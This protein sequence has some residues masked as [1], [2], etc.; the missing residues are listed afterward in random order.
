[1]TRHVCF[2]TDE[3][4]PFTTGGIGRVLH[5]LVRQGLELEPDTEFHFLM[6]EGTPAT[7]DAVATAFGPR[8][9][10][11][12]AAMRSGWDACTEFEVTYPPAAAFTD[13]VWHAQS[14]DF[15]R[16]LKRLNAGGTR[17]DVVEFPDYRGWAFC[18][19]QEKLLGLDFQDTLVSVRLHSTDGVLQHFEPRPTTLDQASRWELERKALH[20]A[21]LVIAHLPCIADFNRQHYGFEEAW[22]KKVVFQFPPVTSGISSRAAQGA[23]RNLLFAT[24]IQAF[25]R[26]DVFVRGAALYMRQ[27]P[28]FDGAAVVA[29]HAADVEYA[30]RIRRLVPGDLQSRFRFVTSAAERDRLLACSTLVVPSAYESLNLTAYE[31]SAQGATLVLNGACLAFGEGT[32]FVDGVNCHKYDGTVEGLAAA[33]QR[34]Q[35]QARLEPVTTQPDVPYWVGRRDRPTRA[36]AQYPRGR[37]SVVITNYNLAHHL[38]ETLASVAGSSYQDVE[39]VVVDDA[40]TNELDAV[41]MRKLEEEGA[42]RDVPIR[43]VRNAV[44]RGLPGARNVGI[45]AASGEYVVPL[46]AD[47]TISPTFLEIAVRALAACPE[48]DAVVPTAGYF[49]SDED[50][51]ERRFFDYAVFLGDAPSVGLV[52][53]RMS[54]ATAL[55]RR[56]VFDRFAYDE[57][58][59]SFEDWDLYLRMVHAGCRF[60]VTNGVHFHYR[61]RPG[62]MIMGVTRQRHFALLARLAEK[63]SPGPQGMRVF[64]LVAAAA[65]AELGRTGGAGVPGPL[66]EQLPLRYRLADAV[67]SSLK[68]TPFQPLLKQTVT[69]VGKLV[70]KYRA[71]S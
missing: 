21:E 39:V 66:G 63:L 70:R 68:R 42:S 14:L 57:A 22:S 47:D 59:D 45:R 6:P 64:P 37:V 53:N 26:P 60:L 44:N 35:R 15:L 51:A 17:F 1:M 36:W 43:V 10:L 11:H 41:V 54:C 30:D 19:L 20:D 13:T 32:P 67:N 31:A 34:A 27:T 25:K 4:Y 12:L 49:A 16:A 61:S 7:A 28:E 50:V 29:C 52:A 58:L 46:D 33:L 48:Y 69:A 55:L 18:T 3:L 62:S 23:R 38:P 24:K 8:V 9:L 56:S 40:S 5:N 65:T 2:V 71:A